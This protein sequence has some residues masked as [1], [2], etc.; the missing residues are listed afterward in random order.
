MNY[1]GAL[2]HAMIIV[3]TVAF[4]GLVLFFV[5]G[6][7]LLRRFGERSVG[8]LYNP[9]DGT[10]AR[11][12]YSTAEARVKAGRYAEAVEEYRKVIAQY[13]DDIYAH[14]R[15]ADL[16][17]QHLRDPNLAEVELTSALAKASAEDGIVLAAHRLA[18]FY[19]QTLQD[20]P[21]AIEVMRQLQQRLPQT[22]H[23]LGAQQRIE[24]LQQRN[25]GRAPAPP[26]KIAY[27]A[28]D[29]ETLRKRRG[30]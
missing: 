5:V 20:A 17:V 22:K 14:I 2:G 6:L 24:I 29:E 8:G 15:I 26:K 25:G 7:P 3:G 16:A 11:P 4:I 18:D 21:R 12:E 13:P 10:P 23:A 27:R 19:Q 1:V 28:T 9:D 30:F